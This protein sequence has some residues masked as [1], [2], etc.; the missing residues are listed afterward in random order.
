MIDVSQRFQGKFAR[1][2]PAVKDAAPLSFDEAFDRIAI[3]TAKCNSEKIKMEDVARSGAQLMKLSKYSIP[4][5]L[6]LALCL[7]APL[8]YLS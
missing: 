7:E 1:A 3:A 8:E 5:F 4:W 2:T 6:H